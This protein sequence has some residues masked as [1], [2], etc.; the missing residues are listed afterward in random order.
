MKTSVGPF[1]EKLENDFSLIKKIR[2]ILARPTGRTVKYEIVDNSFYFWFRFVF[3][4]SSAVEIGNYEFLKSLVRRDYPS[5]SEKMLERYFLEQ[6]KASE[7][8]SELGTYWERGNSNEIDIDAVNS[9]EKSV[10]LAEVKGSRAKIDLNVLA[11]KS[12]TLVEKLHGYEI[13]AL[14]L[15][16]M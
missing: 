4:N 16:D 15:D 2:P 1:L 10:V 13:V 14:S 6:Y 12:T 9:L 7:D 3:K 5:S 11:K 8:F